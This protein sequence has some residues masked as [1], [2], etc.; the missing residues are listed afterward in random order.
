MKRIYKFIT[1]CASALLIILFMSAC[2]EKG[3]NVT[4]SMTITATAT[5][6]QITAKVEDKDNVVNEKSVRARYAKVDEDGTIGTYSNVTFT[7]IPA[8]NED[9]SLVEETQSAKGLSMN[10]TYNVIL[11]CTIGTESKELASQRVSTTTAGQDKENPILINTKEELLKISDDVN[12]YYKL[13]ADIDLDNAETKAIFSSGTSAFKG[14]FDGNNHK[15]SNFSQ[16]T[17]IQYAGLFGY[18]DTNAVVENLTIENAKIKV[19][20]G[21]TSYYGIIAGYNNGSVRH[22][23]VNNVDMD[24]TLSTVSQSTVQYVGAVIGH[25]D[26]AGVVSNAYATGTV[27]ATIKSHVDMGGIVGFNN[28]M[29]SSSHSNQELNLVYDTTASTTNV[30]TTNVGGLVGQTSGNV[31]NSI[32]EGNLKATTSVTKSSSAVDQYQASNVGGLAGL[33]TAGTVQNNVVNESIEYTSKTAQ[34]M[35][36]GYLIGLCDTN[37]ASVSALKNNSV[38]FKDN[39]LTL[40]LLT[41]D[42]DWQINVANTDEET[43]SSE[44]SSSTSGTKKIDRVANIGLINFLK[45]EDGTSSK[46]ENDFFETKNYFVYGDIL[47]TKNEINEKVTS[48]PYDV[49]EVEAGV[50]SYETFELPNSVND[51]LASHTL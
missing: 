15:I 1:I 14:H 27:K 39:K 37:L 8:K 10:T 5:T 32:A 36:I 43:T 21:G 13:N 9:G 45:N 29:I 22:I 34:L 40:D 20:R 30:Y 41:E 24:L 42:A 26:V 2:N 7:K 4:G 3:N 48:I 16:T 33:V 47:I 31:V 46:F 23:T 12:A 38:I 49:K 44:S 18:I 19:S 25:N 28:G 51:Y 35:N 6:L 50:S 17:S 11:Y